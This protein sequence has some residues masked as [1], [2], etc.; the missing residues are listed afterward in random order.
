MHEWSPYHDVVA[1]HL[2]G[3]LRSRR[4]EFRLV[5]L[6]GG[7][8]RLEGSTWYELDLFPRGYFALWSDALIGRIHARVLAH[9][10]RLSQ[11]P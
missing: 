10:A 6:A 3:Y 5:P 2:Y 8:T 9:V 4:G 11:R 7:R 1:P